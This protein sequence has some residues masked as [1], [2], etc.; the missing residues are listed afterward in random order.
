MKFK[1]IINLT[2]RGI[3]VVQERI[4]DA[5]K[6]QDKAEQLKNIQLVQL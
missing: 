2:R 6:K 1:T 4:I 5:G 3:Y